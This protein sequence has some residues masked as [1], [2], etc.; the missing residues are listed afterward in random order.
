M[1]DHLFRRYIFVCYDLNKPSYPHAKTRLGVNLAAVCVLKTIVA[2][3]SHPRSLIPYPTAC[4]FALDLWPVIPLR[5]T[6]EARHVKAVSDTIN[7]RV[8]ISEFVGYRVARLSGFEQ[9]LDSILVDVDLL[10][11]HLSPYDCLIC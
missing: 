5:L 1:C 10:V 11:S 8:R 3:V 4:A 6:H 7:Y 2:K 9:P